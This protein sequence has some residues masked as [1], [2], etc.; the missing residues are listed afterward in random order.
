M[1]KFFLITLPVL[2]IVGCEDNEPKEN[3]NVHNLPTEFPLD[4]DYAWQYLR[5]EYSNKTLWENET[6]PDTS[7]FDT[8]FIGQTQNDYAFYWWGEPWGFSL[9]KNQ[10]DVNHF[11]RTNYYYIE[12]DSTTDWEK[13]N[14]WA[15]YNPVFDTTGYHAIYYSFLHN[16]TTEIDT[17]ENVITHSY[18]GYINE[19]RDNYEYYSETKQNLF[20]LEK[21]RGFRDY[22][23]DE[24]TD[25]FYIGKK[26]R[27]IDVATT[28][29]F[30]ILSRLEI[31]RKST[32][33]FHDGIKV[34]ERDLKDEFY[35]DEIW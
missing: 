2:L 5:E 24:G 32:N 1:K 14:L 34:H 17:S 10:N 18:I 26:L 35:D 19:L 20:G 33:K 21:F 9:V 3:Y 15:N 30:Q 8:L 13:P 29:M 7:Y 4:K 16:R 28:N 25:I 22:Y 6:L 12:E 27:E 11:I 31:K 23:D